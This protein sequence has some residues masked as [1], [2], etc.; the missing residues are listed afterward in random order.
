MDI[1]YLIEVVAS[2]IFKNMQ[3]DEVR[4]IYRPRSYIIIAIE[5]VSL[6][7]IDV[8][9]YAISEPQMEIVYGL[10]LRYC[11]R[12]IRLVY[13]LY[14]VRQMVGHN[15][16]LVSF[17]EYILVGCSVILLGTCVVYILY[18]KNNSCDYND[19]QFYLQL[20][21]MC[22]YVTGKAYYRFDADSE[23]IRWI[24]IVTGFL[25]Y[26]FTK[27]FILGKIICERKQKIMSKVLFTKHF[28]LLNKRYAALFKKDPLTKKTFYRYYNIFW[29]SRGGAMQSHVSDILPENLLGEINLDLSWMALKHSHLFRDEKVHFLHLVAG[30]IKHTFMI[31]GEIIYRRNEFKTKMIYVASGTIQIYSEQDGESPIMS[32][33]GGTCLGESCLVISY[34]SVCTVVCK[35]Q[36]EIH[37]LERADFIKIMDK[38]P[39]HFK[40]LREK[41]LQR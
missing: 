18:C 8:F 29:H 7:P 41:V 11:L 17:M 12:I 24:Y 38:Y 9:Y 30:Y 4:H 20:F 15:A 33:S 6:I 5:I 2:I 37:V 32:L 16:I 35:S 28:K 34:P 26:F 40:K 39:D 25:M 27:G 13:E 19:D 23:W 1:L 31:P 3:W 21:I 14:I 10:R 36:C 22:G